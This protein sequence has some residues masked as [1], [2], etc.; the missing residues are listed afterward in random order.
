[1]QRTLA[2]VFALLVFLGLSMALTAA[3]SVDGHAVLL[4]DG[5]VATQGGHLDP[6][7]GR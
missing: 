3:W 1:M 2:E 6:S 7:Q 4:G 5:T